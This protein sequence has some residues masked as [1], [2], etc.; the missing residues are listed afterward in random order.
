MFALHPWARPLPLL[1][2]MAVIFTLSHQ[3]GDSFTLPEIINIDKLLHILVYTLLG[4]TAWYALPPNWRQDHPKMAAGLVV[5]C[6]LLYGVTD[7][8]HQSFIPGRLASAADIAADTVGGGLA[9]LIVNALRVL[10][11]ARV[12]QRG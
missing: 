9:M 7:E 3:P 10:P 6:C 4:L 2:M 5:G 12:R 8:W 11:V 1:S